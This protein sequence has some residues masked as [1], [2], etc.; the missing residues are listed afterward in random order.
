M[1]L[2]PLCMARRRLPEQAVQQH[3]SKR[4]CFC[5]Y[6]VRGLCCALDTPEPAAMH[7]TLR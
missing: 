7:C 3:N 1:L 5:L 2:L 4:A 6:V